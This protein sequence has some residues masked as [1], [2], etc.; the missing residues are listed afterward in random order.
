MHPD[1]SWKDAIRTYATPRSASRFIIEV[2]VAISTSLAADPSSLKM[3]LAR[4]GTGLT[5]T[6]CALL[7]RGNWIGRKDWTKLFYCSLSP[8][9]QCM[10][11]KAW[12]ISISLSQVRWAYHLETYGYGSLFALESAITLFATGRSGMSYAFRSGSDTTP[13]PVLSSAYSSAG[14]ASTDAGAG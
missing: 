5:I 4:R 12:R 13:A 6:M 14:A 9:M 2:T 7:H 8:S 10:Q 1:Q 11:C 3:K